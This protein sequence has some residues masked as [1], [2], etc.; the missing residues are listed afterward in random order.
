MSLGLR[1]GSKLHDVL[2]LL[3]PYGAKKL[4]D[5]VGLA[6]AYARHHDVEAAFRS[7]RVSGGWQISFH[8]AAT[9]IFLSLE[10]GYVVIKADT[11]PAGPGYHAFVAGFIHWLPRHH[12][13]VW[14]FRNAIR[15]FADDTGYI[16]NRDFSA[17]QTVMADEFAAMCQGLVEIPA[18]NKGPENVWLPQ[19]FNLA[20]A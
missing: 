3:S 15:H 20:S 12:Q 5:L 4:K 16:Q 8:P 13:W 17:L 7:H 1:G 6:Q 19:A 9:D 11:L 2:A 18:D 10:G 14:E